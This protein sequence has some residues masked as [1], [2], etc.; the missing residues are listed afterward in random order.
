MRERWNVKAWFNRLYIQSSSQREKEEPRERAKLTI[1]I[2]GFNLN[3]QNQELDQS[4]LALSIK[5][6]E[7]LCVL[8]IP[9]ETHRVMQ[10]D[11]QGMTDEMW[12]NDS[13]Q[14]SSPEIEP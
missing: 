11:S 6:K 2:P 3:S 12:I 5:R 9:P 4:L 14:L 1:T 8:L 7:S 13:L 10:I